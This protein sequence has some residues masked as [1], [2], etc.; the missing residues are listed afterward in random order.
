[1]SDQ[2]IPLSGYDRPLVDSPASTRTKGIRVTFSGDDY[3]ALMK[4]LG[5]KTIKPGDTFKAVPVNLEVDSVH[6]DKTERSATMCVTG[7]NEC[8]MEDDEA[9]PEMPKDKP[10]AVKSKPEGY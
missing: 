4:A 2:T 6:A 3:D 1:M 9:E 10:M 8:D 5:E 7:L